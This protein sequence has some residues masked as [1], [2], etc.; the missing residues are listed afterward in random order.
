M[1]EVGQIG[2]ASR[3]WG[4]LRRSMDGVALERLALVDHCADVA[5]CAEALLRQETTARRLLRLA[6][7]GGDALPEA[8]VA[9]LCAIAFLHDAGKVNA[10]FQARADAGAARVGHID[11]LAGLFA[12][13]DLRGELGLDA[14]QNG[15][16]PEVLWEALCAAFAH[17][18][19]PA[20]LED[21]VRHAP[22]WRARPGYEPAA[23]LRAIAAAVREAYPLAFAPGGPPL[24]EAPAFWHAFAGLVM[25]ADWLGS[26]PDAFPFEPPEGTSRIARSRGRAAALLQEIGYD[27]GCMR[28]DFAAPDFAAV[29][30]YPPSAIQRLAGEAQGRLVTLEAETGAGK[31]EAALYRFARLFALGRVEGLFFAL[32]TRVAATALFERVRAAVARMFPRDDRPVV[33]QAVPGNVRADDARIRLLPEFSVQWD[34]EADLA[35]RRA[36]WAAERPKRFLAGTIAVGTIDQALLGTV[37]VRHAHL[38][39]F[40]L[41][42]SL[43]VVDEVHASDAYMER[44]LVSL[45]QLHDAAGGEA[46]LLSATLGAGAR[47]R[48]LRCDPRARTP[49]PEEAIETPYPAVSERVEGRVVTTRADSRHRDKR[50]AV[51]VDH[52]IGDPA[53]VA[54]MALDAA[55]RGAKVLVVRN[56][57]RDA[58]ATVRALG[59]LGAEQE[60]LFRV[61]GRATLHHG[62]FA[63]EDRLLLDSA[64]EGAVGRTRPDG[65][66]ILVGTQTLEQSLDIDADV[67]VT[68]LAPIDVLL[69]RI[70][71]LH[72]HARERPPGFAA[73]RATVLAPARFDAWLDRAGRGAHGLGGAVYDDLVALAA[74]RDLVAAGSDWEIPAM[75]RRLVEQGTHPE[76]LDA[77]G[78]RL[79]GEDPRWIA[80][81]Q[82]T[83][84]RRLALATEGALAAIE[85]RGPFSEFSVREDQVG[86]RLGLRDAEVVFSDPPMGPFGIPV[87]RLVVPGWWEPVASAIADGAAPQA[88]E[89]LAGGFS[90]RVGD[91]GLRYGALGLE[92]M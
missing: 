77:F 84:G 27:S 8:W 75:N 59:P 91:T 35:A 63:R 18:G 60:L 25:L 10:G 43:L 87:S 11:E 72:R 56:T 79:A 30:P 86:T 80:E 50:V 36:R 69:Q 42:R 9:R 1:A 66:L 85:W 58:V 48:L 44:L 78:E 23:G 28:E 4:K 15:G 73:A 71:R 62:R 22:L 6:G 40:S 49:P 89:A 76:L 37:C 29:S 81:R 34:D 31:T 19:R 83:A 20:R 52:R 92:R 32:P 26:D 41:L 24:P 51:A 90:F 54:A 88:V 68:D 12:R 67:L 61:A 46:L 14:M 3:P 5:A 45:L 57:V 82:R 21:G 39:A 38:R 64:V 16:S 55:R 33:I 65:G 47:E 2:S 74:A 17:H 7:T 53:A 70:G 13:E